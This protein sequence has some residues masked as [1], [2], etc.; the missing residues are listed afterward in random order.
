MGP[1]YNPNALNFNKRNE[2]A[3]M[4]KTTLALLPF[5]VL[6]GLSCSDIA[7]FDRSQFQYDAGGD[8]SQFQYDVEA[9]STLN[10]VIQD[11]ELL[12]SVP[13]EIDDEMQTELDQG[14]LRLPMLL[15]LNVDE[16]L[17]IIQDIM[18]PELEYFYEQKSDGL[19]VLRLRF[20]EA[21]EPTET[22]EINIVEF[23]TP[24]VI[25]K[26]GTGQ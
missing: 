16:V 23:S 10:D 12:T 18:P 14:E 13:F 22:D 17:A 1:K 26:E 11:L 5:I 21:E 4:K 24:F 8:W 9:N 3:V 6:V 25:E 7:G 19:I 20:Q 15:G 2:A